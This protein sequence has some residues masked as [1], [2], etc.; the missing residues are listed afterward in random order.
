M[1]AG[2]RK[3]SAVLGAVVKVKTDANVISK[4]KNHGYAAPTLR[5][6]WSP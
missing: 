6:K 1:L 5:E 2:L 4:K 3:L